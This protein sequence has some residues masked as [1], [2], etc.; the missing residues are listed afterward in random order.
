M[1]PRASVGI[2]I[3]CEIRP[4]ISKDVPDIV[5][6]WGDLAVHHAVLDPAFAPSANWQ[7]EYRHFV[8]NLLDRDDALAVVATSNGQVIGYGVGRVSLLPG[9]CARR[10]RGYIHDVVTRPAHRRRGVGRRLVEALVEWMQASE[11][12]TV[13]LTVA[14]RNQEALAFWAD[15]GFAPYM[16]HLKRDLG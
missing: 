1:A 10:R 14:I 15:Q 6:L 12:E 3:E 9:F 7:E 13:E 8:R 16:Q 5:A 4:A 2:P 11:V